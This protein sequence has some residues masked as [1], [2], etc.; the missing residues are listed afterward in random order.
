MGYRFIHT[1]NKF[2]FTYMYMYMYMY[3]YDFGVVY[4]IYGTFFCSFIEL[5]SLTQ[6]L[7]DLSRQRTELED[8]L[9][10]LQRELTDKRAELLPQHKELSVRP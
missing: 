9:D 1:G 10:R 6:L 3:T 4:C 2:H 5:F 7:G 8:E